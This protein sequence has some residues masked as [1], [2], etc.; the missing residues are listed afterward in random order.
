MRFGQIPAM[1]GRILTMYG[2]IPANE[3]LFGQ[4]LTNA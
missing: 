3:R 2:R 1:Y 4:I